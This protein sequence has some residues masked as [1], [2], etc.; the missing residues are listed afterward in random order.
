M[1]EEMELEDSFDDTDY[2]PLEWYLASKKVS[3]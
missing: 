2:M 3:N 1:S